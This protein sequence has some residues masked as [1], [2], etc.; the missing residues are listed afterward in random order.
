[1]AV[2][3]RHALRRGACLLCACSVHATPERWCLA[4]VLDC[5]WWAVQQH[6]SLHVW[7]DVLLLAVLL[8]QACDWVQLTC[9]GVC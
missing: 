6:V 9:V 7:L 1:M 8:Q 3:H 4:S 2:L 5:T